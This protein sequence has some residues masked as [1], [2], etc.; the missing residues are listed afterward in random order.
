MEKCV[1]NA[2]FDISEYEYLLFFIRG[3]LRLHISGEHNTVSVFIV[4]NTCSTIFEIS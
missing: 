1:T 2:P 4:F 3:T